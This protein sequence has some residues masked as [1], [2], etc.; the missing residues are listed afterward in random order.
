MWILGI[1]AYYHDSAA[2]LI[3]DGSIVAAAQE[4]RFNRVKHYAGFPRQSIQF[5]LTEA[6]I[7]LA[8]ID[9]IVFYEK[10][11]LRFERLLETYLAFAP[12]GWRSFLRAMP[13]WLKEK[14]FQKWLLLSELKRIA[15]AS[16]LKSRLRFCE[17]HLS[18]AASAFYS[19]PFD[20]SLILVMD[21]VGEWA[22]T[23]V[24]LG[25]GQ[26]IQP[27]KEIH[28]P[29]SL[30]LLYSAFTS[31]CGFRVNDGEYKLMGLAPYG[32]P[33]Y[34]DLIKQQLIDIADDG[35]FCLDMHYFDYA[36]GLQMTNAHFHQLF[37]REPRQA[38]SEISQLD[39]DLAASIQQVCEEVVLKLAHSLREE[40]QID[41]LCL[42]GG[43][44]L[45]CVA[46]GKLLASEPCKPLWIQPAAGDAGGAIGCA[47]AVYHLHH[48]QPRTA[49]SGDVMQ[50][51]YLGPAYGN[52]EIFTLL[53][54]TSNINF[55]LLS[56][57]QLL[58]CAAQSLA[59]GK[60][61]GW[62]QGRM[63]FGPRALGARSILADARQP[64]MQSLINQKIKFRESFRPFAP[65]VL[66]EEMGRYFT[67]QADS[68]YML[69]VAD[70]Q[71]EQRTSLSEDEKSLCGFEQLTVSRSTIPAV[72]HVNNSARIQTV[73]QTDNPLFYQ[74]IKQFKQ[75]SGCGL[76]LNTS[77][78]VK[79]EPIVCTPQDALACLEA[80]ELDEVFIGSY[81]VTKQ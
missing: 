78:N 74:L 71:P 23:S 34:V 5:C 73:S 65:A 63:E 14:L 15:P 35:S 39:M 72:T 66:Q 40:Y 4:E 37:G 50:G 68:P 25:D 9:S 69:L 20:R 51:G 53:Q 26:T 28:F 56:E 6:G 58:Q 32:E 46:N 31:Y 52:T 42:A 24:M 22:T 2:A 49:P 7:T 54:A 44:A 13:L 57:Q 80:T 81:R 8:D 70:L 33:R 12:R 61:I 38:D 48:Q 21:G 16:E 75:I 67:L 62:F 79:D 47:L 76:L 17:H 45:N 1:S 36:T 60:V 18:H 29:H 19:S 27:L 30:G 64:G 77:F 10:P 11:L 41:Q 55:E 59:D 43:V 3:K